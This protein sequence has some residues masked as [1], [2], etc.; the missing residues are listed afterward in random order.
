M[1]RNIGIGGKSAVALALGIVLA[2]PL[3]GQSAPATPV[4]VTPVV[5]RE[6]PASIK[7]VGTV[8]ADRTAIV[9]AE[10]SGLVV[11]FPVREG[12]FLEKGA[13]LCELDAVSAGLR[14]EEA[15]AR[16]GGLRARLE[17]LE[18]GTRPE[19]LRQ[20]AAEVDEA[21]AIYD[22]WEF[23]R[24]RVKALFE[25][26]QS[27]AKEKHDTEM[28]YL[29][30]KQRLSQT[31][32]ANE[33]AVNGPRKE[34]IARARFD[35]AAQQAVVQRLERDLEKTTIR[36][37]FDGFI[38]ARRTEVGEWIDDGGSVCEMI[39]I[40]TVKIRADA[41]ES[42]IAYARTGAPATVNID[43]LKRTMPATITRVIPRAE[44]TA[45]TFPIEIDLANEDH[46]LLPGMFVWTHV[47]A[48]PRGKRLMVHK[49]AIVSRGLAKQVFVIR[50][51]ENGAEMAIPTPVTTGLEVAGEI[52]IQGPGIQPGDLV[53]ARA[54]E[55]LFAPTPV[56]PMPLN[57]PATTQPSVPP[58]GNRPAS[59]P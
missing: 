48:G 54:N 36:A 42:T 21:K 39:A 56:I 26:N 11:G 18:N 51:G 6:V 15:R 19:L 35:V 22:K 38:V 29:A 23:E 27:S 5:Q 4:G 1:T 13:V 37:P 34:Q 46:T 20:L 58:G 12:Q 3:H 9:A 59:A 40:E 24:E 17:E 41:P 31:Q 53:V 8:L 47:P 33:I 49:D 14:L 52:E 30:A 45:R 25:R 16:L 50:P 43:A 32:A 57:A 2:S 7:L 28:E 44:P 10:V 55:R